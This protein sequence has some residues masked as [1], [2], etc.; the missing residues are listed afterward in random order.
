[1]PFSFRKSVRLGS[2]T[3]MNL[4]KSGVGFSVGTRGFRVSTGPRGTYINMG[5][6]GIHYRQ[7]IGGPYGAPAPTPGPTP[8][9][10]PFVFQTGTP[11]P[12]ASADELVEST[13]AAVVER[14]NST[15]QQ[16]AYAG[17]F[18]AGGVVGGLVFA[19]IHP[20]LGALVFGLALYLASIARNMDNERRTYS[21]DY[22]L[23]EPT[24]QRWIAMNMAFHELAKSQALWRITTHDPTYDWK[25]NAG[26]TS[27]LSRVN[28]TL[29]QQPA[30]YIAS[31]LTPYCLHI[32]NQ[33]IFFFPDRIYIYQNKI[34]GAVEYG[35]L[36]IN[37]GQ[38]RFIESDVL[39]SDAQVVGQTWQYVNKNGGPD[40]RFNSNRQ[41]PIA[42][43]GVVE[44]QSTTGLNVILHS[45][46]LNAAQ[47][48]GALYQQARLQTAQ[49]AYEQQAQRQQPPPRPHPQQQ[50]R[51]PA[52]TP[53][54]PIANCYQVLGLTP[55]CT[56][57]E[58]AA[59]YRQ[60]ANSYHPDRV[61]H[62]APEFKMLA[63][64]KMTEINNAISELKRLRGW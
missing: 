62:L 3:R 15:I 50:Q 35:A 29:A 45:S 52:P 41:L 9:Q 44:L 33:H 26:A 60:L 46:S 59:K 54:P 40:R 28:S 49:P 64:Q 57:E 13:S 16:P 17:A 4:S 30:T 7:K 24:R 22:K 42:A 37:T 19:A 32:G 5:T 39:P 2:G 36:S 55:A 51:P 38:T 53:P 56:K 27:L 12:N 48:F 58:A 23:D 1:M 10:T 6:G 18:I 61:N 47:Q 14:L 21:L 11:I 8:A 31:N 34:Y 20:I 43:Y 63:H 25:R